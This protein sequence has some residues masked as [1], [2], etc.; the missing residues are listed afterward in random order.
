MKKS[1]S[2]DGKCPNFSLCMVL[3]ANARR[4]DV[5]KFQVENALGG[6]NLHQVSY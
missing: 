2:V 1:C 4:V 3:F 5:S 6:K